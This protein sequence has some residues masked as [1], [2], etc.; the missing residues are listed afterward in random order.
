MSCKDECSKYKAKKPISGG[1]YA[2]GQR[3]CQICEIYIVW[4]GANC[5]CCGFRLR[6]KP[7]GSRWRKMLG[8]K[9]H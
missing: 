5:P 8:R 9:T 2:S 7:R 4:E 1:R 3:R 6:T